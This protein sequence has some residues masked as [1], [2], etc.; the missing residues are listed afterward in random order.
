[1]RTRSPLAPLAAL[2]AALVACQST[3]NET[4]APGGAQT[5][6]PKLSTSGVAL[7]DEGARFALTASVLDPVRQED[8]SAQ[9]AFDAIEIRRQRSRVLSQKFT[10]VAEE[11]L[12]RGEIAEARQQF[13]EALD[14]DSSNQRARTGFQRA[15]A[16][17]GDPLG[18]DG[19]TFGE[20]VTDLTI[21]RQLLRLR[22]E[23][24]KSKGDIAVR[25]GDYDEA[26]VN[27]RQA[28]TVLQYNP[29]IATDSLDQ[30]LI[31]GRL[32]EAIRAREENAAETLRRQ[33]EEGEKQLE[34]V[35]EAER[36][37]LE[38]KLRSYYE[39]ANIAFKAQKYDE[40]AKFAELV[41]VRDPG[42]ELAKTMLDIARE[43]GHAK[44][45]ESIRRDYREQWIKTFEEL[46]QMNVPVNDVLTFD[47]DTWKE[48]S[49]RTALSEKQLEQ[50]ADPIR[51][52]V[53]EALKSSYVQVSFEDAELVDVAQFLA[54]GSKVNFQLS[55][56]AK[57]E[58][59]DTVNLE[60]G[61]RSVFSV[62]EALAGN[63]ENFAWQVEDGVVVV[64]TAD[65]VSGGQVRVT[66][67]VSE[68]TTPIRDFVAPE[69]NLI[70]SRGLDPIEEELPERESSVVGSSELESLIPAAVAPESWANDVANSISVTETGQ[71]VVSQTPEVQ[72]QIRELLSDL[73]KATGT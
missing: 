57:E 4:V 9:E 26:I 64:T 34:R 24:F 71:M 63:V 19:E 15:Q 16:L 25:D 67:S 10:D 56:T 45:A 59:V 53:V 13:A 1:M 44:R 51:E 73:R 69:I 39:S 31:E 28:Q 7:E 50:A 68:L 17:L 37:N 12:S 30:R 49:G 2:T 65:S 3:A 5:T 33:R 70:P 40:A 32:E 48:A 38:A 55:T 35:K 58:L 14:L 18:I 41:L 66:Y 21:K 62:L 11:A 54:A 47:L 61:R 60:L 43:A 42:N 20:D 8:P 46:R 27:Y 23:E 52:S 6:E 36:E 72:R 22:A 29:L